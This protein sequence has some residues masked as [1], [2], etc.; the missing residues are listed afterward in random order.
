MLELGDVLLGLL[1]DLPLELFNLLRQ[2][3]GRNRNFLLTFDL[4]ILFLILNTDEP[5]PLQIL[6]ITT[7]STNKTNIIF[8]LFASPTALKFDSSSASIPSLNLAPALLHAFPVAD[9]LFLHN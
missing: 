9:L 1:V 2:R 8:R 5:L 4:K 6:I 7:S 3:T